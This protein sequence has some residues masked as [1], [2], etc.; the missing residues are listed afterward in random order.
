MKVDGSIFLSARKKMRA[1]CPGKG[2]NLD[3]AIGTQQWVADEA[4]LSLR[5]VQYLEKGEAST[6]TL[7]AVAKVLNIGRWEESI[8]DYGSEYVSCDA[9][10]LVD[11][12]PEVF[13]PN[14]ESTFQSA[15]LM[16]SIDP[17]SILVESG[18]FDSIE[19]KQ[20]TAKLTGLRQPLEFEWLA[21][22]NL[23]P[24]GSGWLGWVSEVC[25]ITLEAND[26]KTF[27]PILFKQTNLPL[28]SW[29]SFIDETEMSEVNQFQIELS[30][31]F[32]RFEKSLIVFLPVELLK[33]LFDEGRK[34]Y[35]SDLPYRVQL[36]TITYEPH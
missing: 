27:K 7:K 26:K 21:E 23:T 17:V 16:M 13:P 8:K 25:E 9:H 5:A 36:K 33:N 30:F 34:K 28:L 18:R 3:S 12:R 24:S 1:T 19:L 6:K 15:A 10:N 32:S 31:Q 35:N 20:I 14:N 29:Q 4:K 11:F 22:V 2:N